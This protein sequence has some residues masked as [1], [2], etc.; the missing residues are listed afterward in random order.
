MDEKVNIV[1]EKESFEKLTK[2]IADE[3]ISDP[4]EYVQYLINRVITKL[5]SKKELQKI[6]TEEKK[7]AKKVLKKL[8]YV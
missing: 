2:L 7:D 6:S 5:Q 8:G 4:N 3:T 1:I